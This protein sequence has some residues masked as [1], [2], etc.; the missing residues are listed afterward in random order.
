MKR[1]FVIGTA[2]ALMAVG[3]LC[4]LLFRA[5]PVS[6]IEIT[7]LR[8]HTSPEG[9]VLATHRIRNRSNDPVLMLREPP[10]VLRGTGWQWSRNPAIE[11]KILIPS[12][13]TVEAEMAVPAGSNTYRAALLIRSLRQ[14]R[15][16]MTVAPFVA[17]HTRWHLADNWFGNY[18]FGPAMRPIPETGPEN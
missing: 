2:L 13:T 12:G 11:S 18:V 6:A 3:L 4:F 15:V 16:A 10:Q 8:L 17:R 14:E 1:R 9:R 5:P 7:L